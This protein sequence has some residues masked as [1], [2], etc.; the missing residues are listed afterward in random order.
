MCVGCFK[1]TGPRGK[2][3]SVHQYS[4]VSSI[5]VDCSRRAYANDVVPKARR[6][7]VRSGLL[8]GGVNLLNASPE[9]VVSL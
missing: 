8:R 7:H 5:S 3:I 6:L 9:D 2:F 4:I 1:E